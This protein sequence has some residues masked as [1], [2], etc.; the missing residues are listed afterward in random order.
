MNKTKIRK[1]RHQQRMNEVAKVKE[2]KILEERKAFLVIKRKTRK[3]ETKER[4]AK[5]FEE[6]SNSWRNARSEENL[7]IPSLITNEW[8]KCTKKKS[9]L[10]DY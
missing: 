1:L 4:S 6:W 5:F 2:Q 8:G 10:D 9:P 3:K 7:A